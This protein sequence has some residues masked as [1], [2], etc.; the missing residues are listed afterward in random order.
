[1]KAPGPASGP[2]CC[3]VCAPP[4]PHALGTRVQ[5]RGVPGGDLDPDPFRPSPSLRT[6]GGPGRG[7]CEDRVEVG[8]V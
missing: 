6:A 2:S 4:Q 8:G 7:Q 3:G 1:M 5:E